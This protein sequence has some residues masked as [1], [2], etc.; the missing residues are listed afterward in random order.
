MKKF[1]SILALVLVVAMCASFAASAATTEKIDSATGS[2]QQNISLTY[3]AATDDTT[4][5][6]SV[7][8]VWDGMEFVYN[9]GTNKW[10]PESH[11]YDISNNDGAWTD[12]TATVKVTN[13]SNKDVNVKVEY[14]QNS[15]T[16]V[17]A[18]VSDNGLATL[19]SAVGKTVENAAT[20]TFTIT[21]SNAAPTKSGTIAGIA[22]VTL[23]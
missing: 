9:A 19:E 6:T 5:V 17:A 15:T 2:K 8:V 14:T 13:H 3:N 10:N 4:A 12:S 1:L 7:D 21:A 18:T 22:K 23:S 20:K 16:K 11:A